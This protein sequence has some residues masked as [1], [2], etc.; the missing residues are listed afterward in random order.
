MLATPSARSWRPAGRKS[1]TTSPPPFKTLSPALRDRAGKRFAALAPVRPDTA[2]MEPL[3]QF[4]S[5]ET[6]HFRLGFD[7]AGGRELRIRSR[8]R[9]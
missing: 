1:A 6:T 5:V 2:G 9:R 8:A 4:T 7:P 3:T